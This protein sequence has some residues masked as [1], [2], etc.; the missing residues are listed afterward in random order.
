MHV[1]T[2]IDR[3]ITSFE[4]M[5]QI[6]YFVPTLSQDLQSIDFREEV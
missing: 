4:A 6:K 3:M 5:W 2:K 1:A